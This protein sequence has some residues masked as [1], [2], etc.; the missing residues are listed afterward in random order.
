M[1][2]TSGF[3]ANDVYTRLTYEDVR[4]TAKTAGSINIATGIFTAP[5]AGFYAF[6]YQG[7]NVGILKI[8]HWSK[9]DVWTIT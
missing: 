4:K 9:I 2:R 3:V 1:N 5:V 8:I 7:M 6:T